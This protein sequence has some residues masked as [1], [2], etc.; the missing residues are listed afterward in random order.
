M[1][2]GVDKSRENDLI[3]I[4]KAFV[5]LDGACFLSRA[6]KEDVILFNS[7]RFR[8]GVIPIHGINCS[9]YHFFHLQ[10]LRDQQ[11]ARSLAA[12]V[13]FGLQHTLQLDIF[14][15]GERIGDG[16]DQSDQNHDGRRDTEQTLDA[17]HCRFGLRFGLR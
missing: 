12:G 10:N 8:G 17:L 15:F 14:R 4:G 13:F 7:H 3:R 5:N 16:S 11:N 6:R 9:V 2:V 1:D